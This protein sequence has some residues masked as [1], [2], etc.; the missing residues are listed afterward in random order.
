[1]TKRIATRSYELYHVTFSIRH[2]SR[3]TRTAQF[4][5]LSL[6]R[7]RTYLRT[8]VVLFY[9][10]HVCFVLFGCP[11]NFLHRFVIL[12]VIVPRCRII[13]DLFTTLQI[14]LVSPNNR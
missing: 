14:C 1:M 3:K 7:R 4:W 11:T 9:R 12:C 2:K 13:G 5:I 6:F 10:F 8:L